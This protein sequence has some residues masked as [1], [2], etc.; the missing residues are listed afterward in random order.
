MDRNKDKVHYFKIGIFVLIGI[1]VIVFSLLI[2]GAN[3]IL[4]PIVY[5]ETYFEESVQGIA[6]GTPVKYRGL[7]V[8]YI[9]EI[10]FT[11]EEYKSGEG[12]ADKSHLRSIYVKIAITSRLFTNQSSEELKRFLAKEIS[13][14]LRIKLVTQGLTGTSYLEFDYVN[15]KTSP[16]HIL[17]WHPK[18][19]YVPSVPSTL[20]RLSENAQSIINELKDIDFKQ[21][22]F[23]LTKLTHSLSRVSGQAEV[24]LN[25]MNQPLVVAAQNLQVVSSNLL[26]LSNRVKLRPSTLIF[27]SS[28]PPLDPK[29]L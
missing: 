20:S 23:D 7:Q 17:N 29:K 26:T 27:S 2:L 21:L 16:L 18:F 1:S 5:V 10:D 25:Q 13:Q 22:F 14:G 24:L 28:P 3:K 9:K 8:G 19:F 15:P 4:Q 6:N 11:S 12:N